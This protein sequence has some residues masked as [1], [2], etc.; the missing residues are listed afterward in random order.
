MDSAVAS[1]I[2]GRAAEICL[3]FFCFFFPSLSLSL[4]LSFLFRHLPLARL[5]S[6]CSLFVLAL[7]PRLSPLLSPLLIFFSTG[8]A[9]SDFHRG[10]PRASNGPAFVSRVCILH[11]TCRARRWKFISSLTGRVNSFRLD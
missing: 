9:D 7:P 2:E 11:G 6:V 8:V 1:E 4:S 5:R 3:F 10:H